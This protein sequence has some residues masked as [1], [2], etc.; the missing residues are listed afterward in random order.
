MA[1]ADS[2]ADSGCCR[3]PSGQ[4]HRPT[5]LSKYASTSTS[6]PL[7]TLCCLAM[8]SAS[9]NLQ[10]APGGVRH[11][12]A[13][14]LS[15]RRRLWRA[16]S[17]I[18]NVLLEFDR[19]FLGSVSQLPQGSLLNLP[20]CHGGQFILDQNLLLCRWS[21]HSESEPSPCRGPGQSQW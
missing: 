18:N 9:R 14:T 11:C 6:F 10:Q 3:V 7:L 17:G 19:R 21:L 2:G 12:K 15:L 8:V 4:F 20:S 16:V 1:G 13:H 5:P